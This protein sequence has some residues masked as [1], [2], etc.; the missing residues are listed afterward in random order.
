M[1]RHVSQTTRN[2]M[3][4]IL[5]VFLLALTPSVS[6]FGQPGSGV[7]R[8]VVT[9]ESGALVPG[10][11][12]TVSNASGPVKSVTGADKRTRLHMLMMLMFILR[13]I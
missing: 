9:D 8:G 5:L 2:E 3:L 13:K 12:V 6:I 10:A 11:R 1:S 4:K 7:V